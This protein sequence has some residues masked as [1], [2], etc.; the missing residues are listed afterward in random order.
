MRADAA[1]NF[2]IPD[3]RSGNYTLSAFTGGAVG[4]F[5]ETGIVVT[6]NATNAQTFAWPTIISGWKIIITN[7]AANIGG[8][9]TSDITLKGGTLTMASTLAP[10]IVP[11]WISPCPASAFGL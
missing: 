2:T 10:T 3:V 1:G 11:R 6:A 5:S 8:L 4:E 9:G 7:D